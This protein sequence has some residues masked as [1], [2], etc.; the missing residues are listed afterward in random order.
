[1]LRPL[2]R[3]RGLAYTEEA[4]VVD[5]LILRLI[6]ILAGAFWV[7]A[8]FTNAFFVQPTA[9]AL[10]P[11]A[12][13]FQL[14]LMGPARFPAAILSS[15]GVTIAAGIALLWLGTD[16]LDPELLFAE[17]RL[18]FTV[19][20]IVAILTFGVGSLYVYPRIKRIS[21]VMGRLL[22]EGRPPNADEQAAIGSIREQLHVS[23]WVTVIGLAT[24]VAAMATARY[25]GVVL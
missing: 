20:G 4:V 6:H 21:G 14:R 17:S 8:V 24:A 23:G 19:G 10:G 9:D 15:A 5:I 1:M 25:W 13:R 7:G 22:T 18:G 3:R 11:E 16:G 2:P 12:G